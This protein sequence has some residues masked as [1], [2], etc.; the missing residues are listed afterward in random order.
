MAQLIGFMRLGQDAE[1]RYTTAGDAVLAMSLA[2]NYGKKQDGQQPTQWVRASLW[3]K[4]AES[5]AQHMKKGTAIVAYISDLHVR[6]WEKDGKSGV[7]LEG[8]M[9]NF[10]FAGGGERDSGQQ[11][12][13]ARQQQPQ[14]QAPTR[15]AAPD[16]EDDSIPF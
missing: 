16:F 9:D 8:R 6:E 10:E 3:G 7:S 4:R 15:N 13:P 14:R 12:A 11:Q 5:V 1:L 2:Y